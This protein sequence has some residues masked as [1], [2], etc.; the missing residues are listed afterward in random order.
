MGGLS[1]PPPAIIRLSCTSSSMAEKIYD[2]Q[3]VS[4]PL[5]GLVLLIKAWFLQLA[6]YFIMCDIL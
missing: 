6:L 1:G 4:R 5:R 2:I 3:D